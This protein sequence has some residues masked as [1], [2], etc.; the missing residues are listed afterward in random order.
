M[1]HPEHISAILPAAFKELTM[2]YRRND[3]TTREVLMRSTSIMEWRLLR[4]LEI[5]PFRA[6]KYRSAQ[7]SLI[8]RRWAIVRHDALLITEAGKAAMRVYQQK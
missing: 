4:S 8:K 5:T 6:K 1:T 3:L 7:A 2:S